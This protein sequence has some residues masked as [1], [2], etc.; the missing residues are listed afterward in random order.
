VAILMPK[1]RAKIVP[2]VKGAIR[3]L[4]VVLRSPRELARLVGGNLGN[5]LINGAALAAAAHAYGQGVGLFEAV[6]VTMGVTLFTSIVP[7]PGGIGVAEAG[8]TAGLVALGVPETEAF[9]AA[10]TYRFA[11]YYLPPIWGYISLRWL[12]DKGYV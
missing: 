11:T 3:S 9:A 10:I 4:G 6:V 2:R 8:L 7:V 1:L 5:E 12:S